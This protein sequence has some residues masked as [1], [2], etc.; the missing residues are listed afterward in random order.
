MDK[1]PQLPRSPVG[2]SIEHRKTGEVKIGG[3]I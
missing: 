1:Y 2:K 3:K